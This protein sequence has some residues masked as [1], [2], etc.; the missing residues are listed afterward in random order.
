M[1]CHVEVEV[2]KLFSTLSTCGDGVRWLNTFKLK[3]TVIHL[4]LVYLTL[5][6][7]GHDKQE[8]AYQNQTPLSF[9]SFKKDRAKAE[10][11]AELSFLRGEELPA[12]AC[13]KR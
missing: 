7:T 1:N 10:P 13:C 6:G 12:V 8:T 11:H 9:V 3:L 4:S 5:P 2:G